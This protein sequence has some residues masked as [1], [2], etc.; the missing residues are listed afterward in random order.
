MDAYSQ[1]AYD[2]DGLWASVYEWNIAMS[3][4]KC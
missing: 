2:I 4:Y 1:V 3:R